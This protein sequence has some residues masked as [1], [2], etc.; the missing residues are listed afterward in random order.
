M[1]RFYKITVSSPDKSTKQRFTA[2]VQEFNDLYKV[3]YGGTRACVFYSVY[4]NGDDEYPNLD[5]VGSYPDCNLSGDLSNKEG[6]ILLIKSSMKFLLWRFPYIKHIQLLD[7]STKECAGKVSIDFPTFHFAKYGKTWYQDHF[8]AIPLD[9]E[10]RGIMAKADKSLN[11]KYGE[12][13]DVFY[14]EYIKRHVENMKKVKK[15]DVYNMMFECWNNSKT[16]RGFI[17]AVSAHDCILLQIWLKE[18]I[19]ILM[20]GMSLNISWKIK[21]QNITSWS[22]ETDIRESKTI[23]KFIN[24]NGGEEEELFDMK[25]FLLKRNAKISI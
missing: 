21:V 4:K 6:T 13:F 20:N 15:S 19:K 17:S 10:I 16:Y 8:D 1:Y 18:Y 12:T 3:R 11:K 9:K 25:D 2:S 24:Q 7:V 23:P 22:I 14:K 5:S